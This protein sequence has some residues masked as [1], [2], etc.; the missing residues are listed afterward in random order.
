MTE[1]EWL[2]CADPM[3]M[4]EY[5][6]GKAIA[7]PR[8]LC[9]C[10]CATLRRLPSTSSL[11]DF[12]AMAE[13]FADGLATNEERRSART[14]LD[15]EMRSFSLTVNLVRD[16]LMNA[17]AGHGADQYCWYSAHAAAAYLIMEPGAVRDANVVRDVFPTPL[18]RRLPK[19]LAAWRGTNISQ[20]A[21]GICNDG[22]FDSLPILADALEEAGCTEEAI[23]SH[24]RGPG[25][26]VRGCWVVDL[27]LGKE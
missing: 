19:I 16:C 27:V 26:H 10:T 18:K 3:A 21:Q 14:K 15:A 12:I 17:L 11:L 25:P 5:L 8:K 7:T 6:R 1:E 2:A 24:C 9:L 22:T 20:I 4:V 23:L 13:R